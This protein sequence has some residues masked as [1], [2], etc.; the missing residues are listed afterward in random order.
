[1]ITAQEARNKTIQALEV[2]IGTYTIGLLETEIEKATADKKVGTKLY[3]LPVG[4]AVELSRL[5][6][7]LGYEV[8]VKHDGALG[9]KVIIRWSN[10]TNN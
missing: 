9:S 10:E 4:K 1:M 5:C 7:L 6:T 8:E 3:P 2:S